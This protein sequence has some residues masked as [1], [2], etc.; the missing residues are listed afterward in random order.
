MVQP[1][2]MLPGQIACEEGENEDDE[3]D[4]EKDEDAKSSRSSP[5]L[6]I[7]FDGFCHLVAGTTVIGTLRGGDVFGELDVWGLGERHHHRNMT[8]VN[9]VELCK[10]GV[11][12]KKDL[13]PLLALYPEEKYRMEQLVH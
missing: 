1:T 11:I 13:F 10:V 7:L 2:L 4:D 9:T 8:V 6:Y 12:E 5:R 3:D